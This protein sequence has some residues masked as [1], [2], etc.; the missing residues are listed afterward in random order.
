MLNWI[1][2]GAAVPVTAAGFFWRRALTRKLSAG[3]GSAGGSLTSGSPA[4]SGTAGSGLVVSSHTG[5]SPTEGKPAEADSAESAPAD[6][7]QTSKQSKKAKRMKSLATILIV[8]GLYMFLTQ[9][10]NIIFGQNE[11][12]GFE[13]SLWPE[14]IELLGISISET[15]IYTWFAMAALVIAALILRLTVV[16]RFEVLP[17][18]AQNVIETVVEAIKKYTGEQAHGTGEILCSYILSIGALMLASAFLELFRLR[19]PTSD[20]TMTFALAFMTFILINAYGVRRKGAGGRLKSLASPT[21][22]VFAFRAIA[23]FA[24][25]VSMA[26]RLFGNMLGGMIVMD[27]IYTALGNGA[28]GIPSVVGLFFNVFHPLIQAFIFITLTLTF[29]NEAIE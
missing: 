1:L 18:G 28:I 3:T 23:E 24:I 12:S 15:I 29:V 19:A 8:I 10:V 17:K 16:R 21:P 5:S 11:K 25:P 20:I 26:C 22:V 6:A 27:L 7:L 2:L 14:R 13:F 9:L 4:E